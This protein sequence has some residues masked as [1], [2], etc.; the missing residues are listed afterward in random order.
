MNSVVVAKPEH[1]WAQSAREDVGHLC[2]G[3]DNDHCFLWPGNG[4]GLLECSK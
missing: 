4:V 1:I 3:V 2:V